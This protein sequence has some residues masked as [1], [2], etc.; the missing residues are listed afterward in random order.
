MI[1]TGVSQ[2]IPVLV[3]PILSRLFTPEE[4]GVMAL[5]LTVAS[6]L[7]V[8][9][10]GRL[11]LAVVLP[12]N[13]SQAAKVMRLGLEL[14]LLVSVLL[15][16]IFILGTDNAL[17]FIQVPPGFKP[18]YIW[19][20][21]TIFLYAAYQL[22]SYWLLRK[23]AYW[24]SAINKISQTST[25]T[26]INLVVGL[27]KLNIGLIFSEI[28]GRLAGTL[29]GY[30]QSI[31]NEFI[32][33][34][35]H[36][37]ERKTLFQRYKKFVY[38]ASFPA[39]L[40]SLSSNLP[41]FFLTSWYTA[42]VTGYYQ[43]SRMVLIIPIALVSAAVG[44]VLLRKTVE[45]KNNQKTLTSWYLKIAFVLALCFFPF[46]ITLSFAGTELFKFVFGAE[47]AQS[48]T[49]ATILAGSYYMRFVV[50]PLS[51][52]FPALE[53]VKISG[54]WHIFYSLILGSMVFLK[55]IDVE[56]FLLLLLSV[57]LFAYAI[58][59]LLI[60]KTVKEFDKSLL[61]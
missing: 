20:G 23:N 53:K 34:K 55:G 50:A 8:L 36:N 7:S 54:G 19:L 44:Q 24:P 57:E 32:W 18:Y 48:G 3:S 47:W 2:A 14:S 51:S 17:F 29:I 37:S 26:T 40:D 11:E 4:F 6:A 39:F 35:L 46:F 59:F 15:S 28:L 30:Y 61:A 33:P 38:F 22:L 9:A 42:E 1:S 10:T 49:F 25:T 16:L 41:V 52:V 58:Y 31:K 5:F 21:P 56:N 27:L 13:D 12:D 43:L 45:L 60:I